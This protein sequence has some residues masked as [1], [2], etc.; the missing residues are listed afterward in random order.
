MMVLRNVAP[1]LRGGRPGWA[2]PSL[3]TRVKLNILQALCP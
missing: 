1:S 2:Q 3:A